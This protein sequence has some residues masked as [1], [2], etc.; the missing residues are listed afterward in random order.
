MPTPAERGFDLTF[1]PLHQYSILHIINI[2]HFFPLRADVIH[3]VIIVQLQHR[4][5][6]IVKMHSVLVAGYVAVQ[7]AIVRKLQT[8]IIIANGIINRV[9][10]MPYLMQVAPIMPTMTRHTTN[11]RLKANNRDHKQS[12]VPLII[13]RLLYANRPINSN[14]NNTILPHRAKEFSI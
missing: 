5:V 10:I 13:H 6:N 4:L 8:I 3:L 7:L 2:F 1:S 9:T 12:H 11:K 14:R